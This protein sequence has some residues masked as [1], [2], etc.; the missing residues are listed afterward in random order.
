MA[1][2]GRRRG[3][4]RPMG[5]KDTFPRSQ[6]DYD[7]LKT[8]V[9]DAEVAEFLSTNDNK[10]FTGTAMELLQSIYRAESLPVKIRLP[11]RV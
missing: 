10:E 8:M 3:A 7:Q 11:L 9:Y 2:G 6:K 5:R 1:R 4:G